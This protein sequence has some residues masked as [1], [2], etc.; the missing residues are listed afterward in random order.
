MALAS[1]TDLKTAVAAFYQRDDLTSNM[2]DFLDLCEAEMQ[3]EVKLL[4]FETTGTV[5]ITNGSGTLPTGWAGARSV[6][7]EY[8]PDVPL[9]YVTPQ[10]WEE[11]LAAD[12]SIAY[13][14][15]VTGSTIKVAEDKTGTLNVT[16]LAKFTP[17]SGAATSNAILANHPDA[18]LNGCLKY[19]AL[20][21]KDFDSAAAYGGIF[22]GLLQ[23]MKTDNQQ[24]KY[25]HN[26]AVR[27]A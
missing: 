18:Y 2:D 3:R 19:A 15:T 23:Q 6:S 24:R 5:T 7:W 25:G 16:Y 1:Y 22:K 10:R 21:C 27:A 13:V 8:T 12:Y 11:L 14:Y 20:F 4:D 26:L 9:T 17:L